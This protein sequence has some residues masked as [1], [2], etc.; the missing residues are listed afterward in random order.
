MFFHNI[1]SG[2][3]ALLLLV[4]NKKKIFQ[5]Q[6]G[7]AEHERRREG[8]GLSEPNILGTKTV[9]SIKECLMYFLEHNG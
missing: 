4:N 5:T 7:F 2:Q 8:N 3:L 1:V 9:F 6:H